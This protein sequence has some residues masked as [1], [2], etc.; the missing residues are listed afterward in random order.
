M[1]RLTA[2]VIAVVLFPAFAAAMGDDRTDTVSTIQVVS[3][4]GADASGPALSSSEIA[5]LQYHEPLSGRCQ[6]RAG[7]FAVEPS[8][9]VDTPCVVNGLPGFTLP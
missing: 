2:T 3:S 1:I 5:A 9:P 8:R 6:T 7:V 4:T